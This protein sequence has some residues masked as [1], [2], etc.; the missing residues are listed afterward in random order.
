MT[1]AEW[2][3]TK[4]GS[5]NRTPVAATQTEVA[6]RCYS[7]HTPHVARV[8]PRPVRWEATAGK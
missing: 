3:C 4:C 2:A 8:G 1:T 7:C 6:D 5:T